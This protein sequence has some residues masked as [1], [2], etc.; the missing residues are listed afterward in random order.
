MALV[1]E[2]QVTLASQAMVGADPTVEAP[3]DN[4]WL[5]AVNV[6]DVAVT[7]HP[8]PAPVASPTSNGCAAVNVWF[9]PL[10]VPLNVTLPGAL[11]KPRLPAVSVAVADVAPAAGVS[12]SSPPTATTAEASAV[13]M[14]IIDE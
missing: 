1:A 2:V 6:V 14:F 7:F 3:V 5:P 11:T 13:R 4:V 8:A 12:A 9:D 10:S